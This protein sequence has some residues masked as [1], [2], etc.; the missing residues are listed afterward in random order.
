MTAT[1]ITLTKKKIEI[2]EKE[3]QEYKKGI[4]YKIEDI[5]RYV[6]NN[7]ND[8]IIEKLQEINFL[9]GRLYGI[10]DVLTRLSNIF[11]ID[12]DNLYRDINKF[13]KVKIYN[14]LV[15]CI[16]NENFMFSALRDIYLR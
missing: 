2:I 7:D 14:G 15:S 5:E 6:K 10:Q 12:F 4:C 3:I 16:I 11:N 8:K 9:I 13:M 1:L